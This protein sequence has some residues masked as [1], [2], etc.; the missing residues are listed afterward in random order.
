MAEPTVAIVTG[1][2]G[3]LGSAT[4]RALLEQGHHVAAFDIDHSN[5]ADLA[6]E[7]PERLRFT[8]VDVTSADSVESGVA[9]VRDE[10]GLPTILVNI[11]GTNRIAPLT[12]TTDQLWD[13]LIDLNLK[14]T[15]HC[16]RAVVPHMREAGGGRI[17][18]TT[19]NMG[20][21]PEAQQVAYASAKAGLVGLTRSLALELAPDQITVNAV[22]PV[23]TL[24]KRVAGLPEWWKDLQL[25]KIPFGRYGTIEDYVATVGFLLSEGGAFYTGQVLSPNGGDFMS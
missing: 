13:L 3:G 14:G 7:H 9:M 20:M 24:T 16:C 8:T 19:S 18:N 21:R 12:D 25:S 4:A 22:A 23:M 1:A 17:I 5:L 6:G 2:A 11:A 10:L 15:F